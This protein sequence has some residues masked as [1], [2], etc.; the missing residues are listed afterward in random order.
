[1]EN[2]FEGVEILSVELFLLTPEKDR[3]P[4][5]LPI[6]VGKEDDAFVAWCPLVDLATQGD[7][8]EEV[9]ENMEE[10]LVDYFSDPD[11]VKPKFMLMEQEVFSVRSISSRRGKVTHAKIATTP[12]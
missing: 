9:K 3:R 2:I 10:M 12:T 7:T 8:L 5:P 4:I 1:M 11:T 6:I